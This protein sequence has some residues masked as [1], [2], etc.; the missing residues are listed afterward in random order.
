MGT[1]TLREKANAVGSFAVGKIN[2]IQRGLLGTGAGA[3]AARANLA[4]LRRLGMMDGGE[5][6]LV[7]DQL[8]ESW[9]EDM[10]GQPIRGDRPTREFL[11]AQ[12]ALRFYGQHQQSQKKAMAIN[13]REAERGKY[14][15]A[16][17]WACRR[18][19]PNRDSSNGVQRRLAS[20]ESSVE[21]DGVLYQI[22]GLLPRLRSA[23]IS[24]D[25]FVFASDLYL[26]QFDAAR[27][28]VLA[29]W[30]KDYYLYHPAEEDAAEQA[31]IK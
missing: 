22:Q 3:P 2:N 23:G 4:K 28:G 11:A 14:N 30:A 10:L 5:W 29:R 31:V 17:G 9:P 12:A 21:F 24:L 13:G 26:L 20:I 19:E 8:F 7:G 18:I 15:G 1:L 16:F 27:D 6:M 25:Y